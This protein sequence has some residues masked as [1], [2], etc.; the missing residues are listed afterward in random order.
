MARVERTV[1]ISYRRSTV[2]WVLAIYRAIVR[3]VKGDLDGALADYDTAILVDPA[4]VN[5]YFNRAIVEDQK[6][7]QSSAIDDYQKYLDLGGATRYGDRAAV[8]QK[9]RDLKARRCASGGTDG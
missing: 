7:L 9:I 1:F 2:P 8:E 6:G 5:A 4:Y 3:D